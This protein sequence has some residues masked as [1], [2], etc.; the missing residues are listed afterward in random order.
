MAR[1][2]KFENTYEEWAKLNKNLF[3]DSEKYIKSALRKIGVTELE[4]DE[5]CSCCVTYDGGRH[6]E[7]DANPYSMV[8]KVYLSN[9]KLKL[10]TEDVNDYSIENISA[11]ELCSVAF[12]VKDT[13]KINYEM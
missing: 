2:A 5:D 11:D 9:G 1:K 12:A 3:N 10:D 4:L 8:E 7:Y 6:P 13:I